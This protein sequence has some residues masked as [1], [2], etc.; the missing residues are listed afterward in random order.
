M[1]E[2]KIEEEVERSHE[3]FNILYLHNQT[4]SLKNLLL[5]NL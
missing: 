2:V 5:K 1:Q 3:T 4:Q